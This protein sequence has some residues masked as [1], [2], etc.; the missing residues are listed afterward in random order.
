MQLDEMNG[1]SVGNEEEKTSFQ[2]FGYEGEPE[3]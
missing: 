1:E 2:K 3:K